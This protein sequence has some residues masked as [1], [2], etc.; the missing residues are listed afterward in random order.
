M[1]AEEKEKKVKMARSE[2][3]KKK[4]DN[5]RFRVVSDGRQRYINDIV[6][7]DVNFSRNEVDDAGERGRR[8]IYL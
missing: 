6:E 4:A 2:H 1:E 5:D 8:I 3:E 7:E